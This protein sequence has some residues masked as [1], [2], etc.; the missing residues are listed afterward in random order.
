MIETIVGPTK[1]KL[2]SRHTNILARGARNVSLHYLQFRIKVY[3]ILVLII[4]ISS[5]F[6]EQPPRSAILK[7]CNL[8]NEKHLNQVYT[9]KLESLQC[10]FHGSSAYNQKGDTTSKCTLWWLQ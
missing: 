7:I 6:S 8:Y 10:A 4:N 9:D 2:M 5:C 1:L 3:P